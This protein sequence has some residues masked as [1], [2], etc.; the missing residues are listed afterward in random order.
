MKKL[1]AAVICLMLVLAAGCGEEKKEPPSLYDKGLAIVTTLSG[2][3]NGEYVGYFTSSEIAGIAEELAKQD[4]STPSGVYELKYAKGGFKQFLGVII[5]GNDEIPE[6]VLE[7]LTGFSYLA[8]MINARKGANYLALSSVLT[9]QELFV[10]E[11]VTEDVC[12]IYFYENA[13]P[14]LV[15]YQAGEDGAIYAVGNYIFS[16]GLKEQ[17]IDWLKELMGDDFMMLP[18]VM[19]I[20]QIR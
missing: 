2:E 6:G 1:T 12:Y 10:N 19:E 16:D 9:A 4:Y 14:V 8:N 11:T 5:G 20:T 13:Y 18:E 3:L 17:G 7:K 15:S